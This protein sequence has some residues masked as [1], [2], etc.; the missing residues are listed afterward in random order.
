ML[1]VAFGQ[2]KMFKR[3]IP[4]FLHLMIYV[5]F[6]HHQLGSAR[7]YH[8]WNRGTHRIFAP[9]LGTAYSVAMNIFEFLAIAVLVSCVAFLVRRNVMKVERFTKPEMKGWPAMD[10][11]LILVIE[12]IL[13]L[14][15]LTMNATDQILASRGSGPLHFI[16][17]SF[18][19]QY[20]ATPLFRHERWSIGLD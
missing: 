20:A 3:V 12:I 19:Q 14:A 4:A 16:G 8:R 17:W 13:M 11:N 7:I 18:L 5:G 9:A 10:A 6:C 1:L 2:Q 15:I